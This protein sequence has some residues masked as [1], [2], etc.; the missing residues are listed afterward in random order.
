MK[1]YRRLY[2]GESIKKVNKVKW[3]LQTGAGQFSVYVI[4]I[5]HTRDQLDIFH[6]SLLKQK[7]FDRKNLY[8]VGLAN[9]K[10]EAYQ[11]VGEMLRDTLESGMDGD[12]KGFLLKNIGRI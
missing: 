9:S 4:S 5:S 7:Y 12:I 10:G 11:L 1:F 3:K 2:V 6:C 8:V